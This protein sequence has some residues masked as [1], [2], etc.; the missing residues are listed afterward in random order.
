MPGQRRR[1]ATHP[2]WQAESKRIHRTLQPYLPIRCARFHR[3]V[4]ST[5][6]D[7]DPNVQNAPSRLPS[8]V[9]AESGTDPGTAFLGHRQHICQAKWCPRQRSLQCG[10]SRCVVHGWKG[11]IGIGAAGWEPPVFFVH[12]LGVVGRYSLLSLSR[13]WPLGDLR[14]MHEI[15]KELWGPRDACHSPTDAERLLRRSFCPH[16]RHYSRV[17]HYRSA[18]KANKRVR[19]ALAG[20]RMLI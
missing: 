19:T 5:L 4:E 20:R 17:S 9:V 15:E 1:A 14:V 12:F 6:R 3:T 2:A 16:L 18:A 11:R 8:A 13:A 10:R 7:V